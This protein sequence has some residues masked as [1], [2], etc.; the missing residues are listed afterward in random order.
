MREHKEHSFP[1]NGWS[2]HV[3]N[4]IKQRTAKNIY[5]VNGDDIHAVLLGRIGL[6]ELLRA[7]GEELSLNAEPFLSAEKAET[8]VKR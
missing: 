4:L 8:R 2:S 6:V 3:S 1:V 7:K 5:L